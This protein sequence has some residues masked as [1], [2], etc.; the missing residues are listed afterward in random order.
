MTLN[1][2]SV[3]LSDDGRSSPGRRLWR[4]LTTLAIVD[5]CTWNGMECALRRRAEREKGG[6]NELSLQ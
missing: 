2:G 5:G 4:P 3:A 6:R 1:T